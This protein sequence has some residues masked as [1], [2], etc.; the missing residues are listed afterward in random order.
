MATAP[1]KSLRD[2]APLLTLCHVEPKGY[3]Q[4]RFSS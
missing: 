1:H 2:E 3:N 4:G